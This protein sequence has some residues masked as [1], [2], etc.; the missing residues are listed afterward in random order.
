[1]ERSVVIRLNAVI[2]AVADN[3]PQVLI[4]RRAE[5]AMGL[6][7]AGGADEADAL[8]FGAFDPAHDRTLD[9]ALR[10]WVEAQ[11]GV[12]IGYVE[13][14][15]TFGDRFRDPVELAGGPRVVSVGY[16]ALLHPSELAGSGDAIW[17]DAYDFLPW[18][19]GRTGPPPLVDDVIVPALLQWGETP[20]G[21]DACE[22]RR[23]RIGIAFGLDGAGWDA[24]RVLERYELLYEAGLVPESARDLRARAAAG[25]AVDR[26]PTRELI[27]GA[28]AFDHRRILATAL[29]RIRGKLDYRPVVFELLPQHFTLFELQRVVEALAGMPL[30]KQNFRRLVINGGLVEDTGDKRSRT[31]GRPAALFR[32][33]REVLRERRAPGVRLPSRAG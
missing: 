17:R 28:M 6:H 33:R 3:V 23:E 27:G 22:H 21:G 2:L 29:G 32:F 9:L 1:M 14:L 25:H 26:P 19:D 11:S 24:H 30:H 8:P 18:E 5:G 20:D 16:L 7:S 13:Q 12:D 4:V 31:G 10:G 15:Y